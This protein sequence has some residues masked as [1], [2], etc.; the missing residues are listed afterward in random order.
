MDAIERY[1]LPNGL[2]VVLHEDNASPLVAVNVLYDVGARDEQPHQ[3][4]LA[5]LFEHLM[6][7][8][9]ANAADYDM[10]I[11]KAGGES[12]AFTNAD[13]TNFYATLP[14][15]NLETILWLESDRMLA[16]NLTKKAL[17]VQQKV[18][19]E[20]FKETT[21]NEPYGDIWHHLNALCYEKHP[22][23]VPVI[24]ADPS[25]IEQVSLADVQSFYGKYYQPSN[26]I[27]TIG[28]Y[29][30]KQGGVTGIKKWI[31]KWFSEIPSVAVPPRNLPQ[32]PL[33]TRE[34]RK[35]VAADVPFPALYIAFH[36]PART[37]AQYYACDLLTDVLAGGSS[38]VLY[39]KLLKEAR[40][41]TEIDC[42]QTGS[43]EP[44]LVILEAQ[45]AE[46]ISL[47]TLEAAIW[48]ELEL[49]KKQPIDDFELQ[50]LKNRVES[51]QVFAD[52]NVLSKVIS[53]AFFELLGDANLSQTD[54]DNFL[55]VTAA[56]IQASAQFIFQPE[57]ASILHYGLK[58]PTDGISR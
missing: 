55:K 31:E 38:S 12:N 27:L 40:L 4:G 7:G 49:L 51:Q 28:G 5:H 54:V 17:S 3:T 33:Q 20:E 18:V 13:Y 21:L 46:G 23:R 32:E 10:P 53:L 35:S 30:E 52:M 57:K 43:L 6:F 50:K 11:Q 44:G 22:Y 25:H 15:E 37:D 2:R 26:A 58:P 45:P 14:S 29:F 1:T 24:G 47:E 34:K 16:L 9:S 8:G 48:V 41:V 19:V 42:Y 36:A 39:Q 56:D